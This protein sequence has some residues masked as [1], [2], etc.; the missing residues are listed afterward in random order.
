MRVPSKSSLNVVAL[1][2]PISRYDVFDRRGQ[3]MAIMGQPSRKRGAIVERVWF[4]AS[5]QL[6]LSFECSHLFP[7]L[8]DLLLLL[9]KAHRHFE[10]CMC[11]ADEQCSL[12]PVSASDRVSFCVLSSRAKMQGRKRWLESS[13]E[14]YDSNLAHAS[15]VEG[16]WKLLAR[17]SPIRRRVR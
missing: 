1:H 10:M 11:S 8:R 12:S 5:G 15:S 4:P 17:S 3:Q 16:Q 13:S 7:S 2:G 6:H 14:N 9:R